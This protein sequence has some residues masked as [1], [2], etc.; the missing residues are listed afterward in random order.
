MYPKSKCK[1]ED[2]KQTNIPTELTNFRITI[3]TSVNR[4][5]VCKNPEIQR[6]SHRKICCVSVEA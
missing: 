4:I 5:F 6:L 3:G 2:Y 1:L